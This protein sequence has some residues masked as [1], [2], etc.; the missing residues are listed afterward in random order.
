MKPG[1]KVRITEQGSGMYGR[2]ATVC[3]PPINRAQDVVWVLI[4]GKPD[5]KTCYLPG[6]LKVLEGQPLSGSA[7]TPP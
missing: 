2:I 6:S 4:K 3:T 5:I 7:T 1:T